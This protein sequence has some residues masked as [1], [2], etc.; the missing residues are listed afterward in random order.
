MKRIYNELIK[1]KLSNQIIFVVAVICIL[2]I[3]AVFLMYVYS[4][5][6]RKEEVIENNIQILHQAN[7]NYFSEI[8]EELS[9]AS[10]ELFYDKTFWNNEGWES[11]ESYNQIYNIM[12][13]QYNSGN[14][15]DSIY[16]FSSA[17]DKVYVMDEVSF[18]NIPAKTTENTLYIY[19]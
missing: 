4:Y 12:R 9:K 13:S 11:A 17:V 1:K 18:N 14:N 10:K 8:I 6:E 2:Q 15:I 19:K 7:S 16:L 5:Q 3:A